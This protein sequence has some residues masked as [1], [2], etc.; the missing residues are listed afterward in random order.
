LRHHFIINPDAAGFDLICEAI[1]ESWSKFLQPMVESDVKSRIRRES[2]DQVVR[3][4]SQSISTMPTA[5]SG[6]PFACIGVF[7]GVCGLVAI[8]SEGHLLGASGLGNCSA[9][10]KAATLRL[11]QF[12]VRYRPTHLIVADNEEAEAIDSVVEPITTEGQS[13]TVLRHPVGEDETALSSSPWMSGE[14]GDL[15]EAMRKALAVAVFHVRP[16]GLVTR[17]GVQYFPVHPLQKIVSPERLAKVINRKTIEAGLA[18]GIVVDKVSESVLMLFPN[19]SAELLREIQ[20][21]GKASINSK[22]SIKSVP[23]ITE[24]MW[25]NIAGYIIVPNAANILDRTT[26]HPEHFEWIGSIGEEMGVSAESLVNDPS[27]L[28]SAPIE[29]N[30]DRLYIEQKLMAQ[31]LVGQQYL[32]V[33]TAAAKRLK[34]TEITE[35]AVIPGRVTNIASFGVFVDINAVCDGLVH[36]SQLADTY[37]ES[38]E[39]VVSVGDRVNVRVVKVDTKKRRISLSMKGLGSLAP[40]IRPSQGQ[41]STLADHFKNR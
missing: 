8:D 41:L 40:K 13:V 2:E 30:S 37:V 19:T 21:R 17:I 32:N 9:D 5:P 39:Q 15:D 35:G 11:R 6:G 34:L 4:I 24:S 38:P 18:G 1:D 25:R 33:P 12:M 23:G 7:G 3:I 29:E 26:V 28:R 14:F 10:P 20:K 22:E 36:I 31:L 27:I 16:Q